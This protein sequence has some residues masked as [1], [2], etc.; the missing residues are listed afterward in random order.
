MTVVTPKFGMGASVLRLEDQSFI[1]GAG[2]YTDDVKPAGMLHGYVL[3]SPVA[4]ASFNLGSVEAARSAPGVH[5]VLTGE[6]VAHLGALKSGAMQKQPDGTRAPT[7]DIPILCRDRVNYVGDAVAFVVADSRA[8]AQDAAELI[9][10]DYNAEDAASGTATA[11][12]PGTPLVWPELGSNRAFSYHTGDRA[13]TKAAFAGA[14]HVTRI[15]FVNNRLVCNYMEARSAIGEW[16]EAE[17]RF[18]LT[19]GSQGVHSIQKTVAGILKVEP[20]KLRVVTPD[21]GGGFGP[22]TFVYREHP[23][24]LEAARRL[25]RPVKWAGDRTEHFL[26]DAQGRDNF[27]KAEMAMDKNGRFLGLRVDLLANM[28]A[29]ISQYGPFIPF[30]GV[31][32]STGVYDIQALDVSVTGLYTNTCPVDA[33]RGAGRPEAAFLLEKLVDACARDMDLP[34]DEIR[35][36]NFI[37]PEQFPYRTQT[38][39]LYDNGEFEGHMNL[40]I[41][42]AD[43][44]AFPKRLI[45]AKAR[46]RIRGLGMA[47]YIEACAFPGSEPAFVELNGDGTVTLKIG[48]QTNGQGHATAYAQFISEK[49]NLDIAK[50]HVRQGDTDEL[51]DGGGTGGSRSIP[52]GGVS[53]ARAGEDLAEKIKRIA[54]EELEASAGDIELSD[55]VAR[56]VGTDRSMDFSAI[57]KAAKKPHDLQGFGEFV[58]DEATYPNGTH[59]CEVEIDPDTG[60]TDIVRYTIVDDFG[61]TVNP[62]LLAGQVHGG[63]VQGIGQAL[64]ENTVYGEDGQ[65]LTASFMDYAMPRA[66]NVPFFHFETR[67]VPSTTNALGIKGA[68]EAGTIGSTPAALNAVTDALYRAYGIRHIDMPTTA[69]RIWG[70]IRNAK[71]K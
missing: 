25:G 42:R 51:K 67:N 61:A 63:V 21:V 40:A 35:R 58:Q 65:L 71:V 19:T 20:K 53:A 55:G 30:I 44:K 16:N 45:Q 47:T 32:M 15:E 2:R 11:L 22:K 13:K 64:T 66:D 14:D 27:V 36:R 68:G 10:V 23:L 46:G 54:A 56:I 1:K 12:D 3:R 39:R 59:I 26:T 4:K 48:T 34:A 70:A 5:L 60:A 52:L 18:V 29:Y 28:G 8:L 57:A 31:T 33:Y 6:D 49:L 38:G 7:R 69:S 62:I 17:D 41:E 37:R 24:V 43:W 9:E 50:I